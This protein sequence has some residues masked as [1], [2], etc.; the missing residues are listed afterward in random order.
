MGACGP[1]DGLE[2]DPETWGLDLGELPELD[3]D[4]ETWGLDLGELD[5][6]HE[7]R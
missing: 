5:P 6:P 7:R 1:L 4:P 3:I 2:V